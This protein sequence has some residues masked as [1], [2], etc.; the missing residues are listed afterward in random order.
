LVHLKTKTSLTAQR[1]TGS[2]FK[3]IEASENKPRVT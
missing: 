3:I 2:A 1:I